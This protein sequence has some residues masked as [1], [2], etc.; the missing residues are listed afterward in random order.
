MW[1]LLGFS[2]AAAAWPKQICTM[3]ELTGLLRDCKA[4]EHELHLR[5]VLEC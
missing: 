2:I 1:V 5:T 4:L 3:R